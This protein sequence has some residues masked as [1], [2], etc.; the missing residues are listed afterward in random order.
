MGEVW[1]DTRLA[2][3]P[4]VSFIIGPH[5]SGK[6]ALGKAL[7]QRS[8]CVSLKFNQ[9]LKDEGLSGET[10]EE[11]VVSALIRRLSQEVSPRIVLEDF[12]QTEFQAKFFM[13]N[14]VHPQHVFLLTCSKDVC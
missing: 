8:N 7:C 12:P 13:K 2:M 11:T 3:L 6:S 10:D 9:W 5:A 1:A 14:C 4:Q